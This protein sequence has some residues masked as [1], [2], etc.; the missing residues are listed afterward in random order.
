ML[1]FNAIYIYTYIPFGYQRFL[2]IAVT[3][4]RNML[5][6]SSVCVDER[7]LLCSLLVI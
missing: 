7:K 2:K 6:W 3:S 1:N 5:Q 4:C